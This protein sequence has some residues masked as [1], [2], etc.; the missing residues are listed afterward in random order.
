MPR[1]P[2]PRPS[3]TPC[4]RLHR[5]LRHRTTPRPLRRHSTPTPTRTPT[6]KKIQLQTKLR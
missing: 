1:P 4:P 2:P 6:E 3:T 5:P